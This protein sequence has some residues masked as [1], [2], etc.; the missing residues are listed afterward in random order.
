PTFRTDRYVEL[1]DAGGVF[2]DG[3]VGEQLRP[4]LLPLLGVELRLGPRG[5]RPRASDPRAHA[6][7]AGDEDNA[8]DPDRRHPRPRSAALPD[9]T[10]FRSRGDIGPGPRPSPASVPDWAECGAPPRTVSSRASPVRRDRNL[11]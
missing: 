2:L 1:E 6:S 7:G 3:P 11:L 4:P 5:G 10:A 9:G 8:E